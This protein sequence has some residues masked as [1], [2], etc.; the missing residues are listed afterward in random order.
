MSGR[1]AILGTG[2]G[3]RVQVPAFR[4]AGLDVAA[5]WGRTPE[6]AEGAAAQA[7]VA[8]ASA[9]VAAILARPD[10][11]LVSIVTP[12]STHAELALAALAAGKHV[13]CEKPTARDAGEAA[14][15]RR[16]IRRKVVDFP[17]V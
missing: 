15:G 5:L 4:A 14:L 1:I 11:D 13:V 17:W 3:A 12:P 10:V 6:K 16:L 2:W 7:G 8:F 9:D